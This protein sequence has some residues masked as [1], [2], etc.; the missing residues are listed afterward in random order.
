MTIHCAHVV[1]LEFTDTVVLEEGDYAWYDMY[2]EHD[3]LTWTFGSAA[4]NNYDN[5]APIPDGVEFD[6]TRTA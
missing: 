2:G 5:P 6:G 1:E 4:D 3:V